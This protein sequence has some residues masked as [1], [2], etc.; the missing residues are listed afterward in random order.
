MEERLWLQ[1]LCVLPDDEPC[2][3][4]H[5]SG[6]RWTELGLPHETGGR[7]T[8]QVCEQAGKTDG[9]LTETI[10][11]G[12]WELIRPSLQRG[13]L[14]GGTGS[15]QTGTGILGGGWRLEARG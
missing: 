9:K 1:N 14:T 7:T 5:G 3:P 15:S 4:D 2:A 11:S 12:E 10:A 8:Y 13:Q 6:R